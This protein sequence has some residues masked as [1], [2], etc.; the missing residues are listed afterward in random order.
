MFEFL[1]IRSR[2]SRF[3]FSEARPTR[4]PRR[5]TIS[6]HFVSMISYVKQSVLTSDV[7]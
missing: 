3:W 4:T 6:G 2:M 1:V 7:E 5:K